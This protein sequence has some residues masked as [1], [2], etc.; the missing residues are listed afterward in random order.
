MNLVFA[1]DEG[2]DFSFQIYRRPI[3]DFSLEGYFTTRSFTRQSTATTRHTKRGGPYPN[4]QNALEE[5]LS[6]IRLQKAN[7]WQSGKAS[8][9]ISLESAISDALGHL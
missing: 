8:S 7:N 5:L 9:W 1:I 6:F 2:S 4:L 3:G